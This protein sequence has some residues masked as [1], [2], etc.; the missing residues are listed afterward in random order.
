MKGRKKV[1]FQRALWPTLDSATNATRIG[2]GKL[3]CAARAS[4][5]TTGGSSPPDS[6]GRNRPGGSILNSSGLLVR[7][8]ATGAA[9]T[10]TSSRPSSGDSNEAIPGHPVRASTSRR[11]PILQ[12]SL[13]TS[14]RETIAYPEFVSPILAHPSYPSV[15]AERDTSRRHRR[16]RHLRSMPVEYVVARVLNDRERRA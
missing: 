15:V 1:W 4:P 3:N 6:I 11:S 12:T 13:K 10:K 14:T 16:I 7:C 2:S 8:G 5:I 9:C